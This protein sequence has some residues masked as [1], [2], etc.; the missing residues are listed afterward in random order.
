MCNIRIRTTCYLYEIPLMVSSDSRR[1]N[2][3]YW[4][5]VGSAGIKLAAIDFMSCKMLLRLL[6]YDIKVLFSSFQ[7]I[8]LR[9]EEASENE[10]SCTI[11]KWYLSVIKLSSHIS[12][13]F[14]FYHLWELL[15]LDISELCNEGANC[16]YNQ[17][18]NPSRRYQSSFTISSL[19]MWIIM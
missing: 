14:S 13:E 18:Y 10:T 2:L 3:N 16:F 4:C 6:M 17:L 12:K 9:V 5:E 19:V 15:E 1:N 11:C 8:H 7:G